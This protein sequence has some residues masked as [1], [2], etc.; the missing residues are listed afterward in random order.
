MNSRWIFVIVAIMACFAL[1]LLPNELRQAIARYV[2]FCF[3]ASLVIKPL[4]L[5]LGKMLRWMVGKER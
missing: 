4:G 2:F 1:F 3:I 5:Y